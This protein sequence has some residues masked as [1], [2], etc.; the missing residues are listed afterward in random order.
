MSLDKVVEFCVS[1]LTKKCFDY[2]KERGVSEHTVKKW[3]LGYFPKSFKSLFQV[4]DPVELKRLGI[5]SNVT[6]SPFQDR[7]IFP[8]FDVHNR[9][10][11]LVGRC[12]GD[13]KPKYYNNRFDKGTHLYG[14]N[15]SVPQIRKED[16]VF[17]V[18]GQFDVITAHSKN[19]T[20]VVACSGTSFTKEQLLLLSRYT[21]NICL[22]LDN[23]TAGVK[24]SLTILKKFKWPGINLRRVLLPAH[25]LDEYLEHNTEKDFLDLV[26]KESW[27]DEVKKKLYK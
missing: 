6:E 13:A 23:D 25:D 22:T 2:F 15:F 27:I 8:F 12:F 14:L 3:H 18:E 19:L 7:L 5:V 4:A 24:A 16:R 26:N 10:I 9:V 21:S 17:V 11:A 20:N 1:N